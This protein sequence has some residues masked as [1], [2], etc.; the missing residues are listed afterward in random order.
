MP[1]GISAQTYVC[2]SRFADACIN[3]ND[4]NGKQL[5]AYTHDGHML[6]NHSHSHLSPS[7]VKADHYISDLIIA[8]SILRDWQGVRLWYRYPYLNEGTSKSKRDSIRVA[9]SNLGLMNGYV[10]VDNYDWYINGALLE[11]VKHKKSVN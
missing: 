8:D 1:V 7:R 10:T 2:G 4:E 9:L 3:I 5:K 11:A 6:T